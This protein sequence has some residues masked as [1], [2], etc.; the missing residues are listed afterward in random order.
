MAASFPASIVSFT[1]KTNGE[2]ITPA[3]YNS[4]QEEI[5]ALQTLMRSSLFSAVDA[6]ALPVSTSYT[7]TWGNTGTANTTTN[8]TIAGEYLKMGR[9]VVYYARILWGAATASGNGSWTLTLPVAAATY[10]NF[11]NAECLY[12]DSSLSQY[13]RGTVLPSSTT[14]IIPYTNASPMAAVGATAPFTWA[15][16]DQFFVSGWYFSAA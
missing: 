6:S 5:V 1:T 4:P 11:G 15:N 7:P 16:G 14:V 2:T 8:A 10:G 3:M 12:V 13:Y 9:L